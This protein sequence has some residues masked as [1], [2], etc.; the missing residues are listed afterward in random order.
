MTP[1]GVTSI[2]DV[3]REGSARQTIFN[4]SRCLGHAVEVFLHLT[5]N[6]NVSTL[7]ESANASTAVD[8]MHLLDDFSA[9]PFPLW[10]LYF[11]NNDFI[12]NGI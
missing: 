3:S 1:A 9:L 2:P 8:V 11:R 10:F 6:E 7:C 4:G 12:V 5:Q